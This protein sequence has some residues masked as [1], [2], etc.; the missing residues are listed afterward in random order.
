MGLP[1]SF[2]LGDRRKWLWPYTPFVYLL[3][4]CSLPI[5]ITYA[6]VLFLDSIYDLCARPRLPRVH[7]S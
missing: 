4:P 1:T 3:T 7:C 6:I 5:R 2:V